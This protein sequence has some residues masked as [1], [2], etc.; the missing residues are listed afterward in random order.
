MGDDNFILMGQGS[1]NNA[2]G[3]GDF[4]LGFGGNFAV[5]LEGVAA[6]C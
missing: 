3:A 5:L 2:D 6:K 1:Y 4:F